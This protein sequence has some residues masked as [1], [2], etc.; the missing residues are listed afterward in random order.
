MSFKHVQNAYI[1]I[2]ECDICGRRVSGDAKNWWKLCIEGK[3]HTK[4]EAER[5]AFFERYSGATEGAWEMEKGIRAGTHCK[6]CG[7]KKP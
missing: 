3:P 2:E 1:Y 7:Q 6:E 5:V 4:E